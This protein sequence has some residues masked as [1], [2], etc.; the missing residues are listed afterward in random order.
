MTHS[1]ST[2]WSGKSRIETRTCNFREGRIFAYF[3]NLFSF[4]ASKWSDRINTRNLGAGRSNPPPT[5]SCSREKTC[6]SAERPDNQCKIL[7][8]T[9]G[10]LWCSYPKYQIFQLWMIRN[11]HVGYY[12]CYWDVIFEADF[13]LQDP[14]ASYFRVWNIT[15]IDT[16]FYFLPGL[17]VVRT[18]EVKFTV[19]EAMKAQRVQLYTSFSLGCIEG[20]WPTT[21]P[22][23]FKPG[24]ETR[25]PLSRR[26]GGPQEI[27]GSINRFSS[28]LFQNGS[29]AD[30]TSFL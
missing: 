11:S 13:G 28:S 18:P 3:Q 20:G 17:T 15:N 21:R 4:F 22:G 26:L 30:Q 29:V 24:K 25:Y 7:H 16:E 8:F 2:S 27:T 5:L 23:H 6:Q 10:S 9:T 12:A 1:R 14:A 19:G